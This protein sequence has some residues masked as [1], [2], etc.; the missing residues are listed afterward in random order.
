M[1]LFKKIEKSDLENIN[2][3]IGISFLAIFAF[4]IAIVISASFFIY[5]GII[6][7]SEN[8]LSQNITNVLSISIS[9]ISFSGKYHAQIFSDQLIEKEESIKYIVILASNGDLISKSYDL[10]YKDFIENE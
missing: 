7:S 3:K 2:V 5:Q 1:D 8:R 6:E 4:L 9:R 10:N